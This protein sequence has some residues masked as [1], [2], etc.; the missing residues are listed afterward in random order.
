MNTQFGLKL[1]STNTQLL[2]QAEEAIQNGSFQYVELAVIPNTDI[3]PFLEYD[4]PY[5][6]HATTDTHGVNIA[7]PETYA[8]TTRQIN[9]C[10]DWADK[11]NASTIILHPGIGSTT[12]AFRFLKGLHDDRILIENMPKIG[13]RGEQMAGWSPK[14]I[15]VL[16]G[17]RFGFC[18]DLNHAIKASVSSG[19]P[20]TKM[21]RDF[22]R[23]DPKMFHIADGFLRDG[24]DQ[25]L[26]IGAGDYNIQEL[27]SYIKHSSSHIV[28]LE[29]GRKN[30]D[31]ISEDLDNLNKIKRMG[32]V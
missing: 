27:L 12:A 30:L 11:L 8:F 13:L 17:N 14:Q 22:L 21:I 18:L 4:L 20:Y 31:S 28:T 26:S 6:I 10:I 1:W 29:T 16:I 23:L 25:H 15:E 19:I 7:D 5:Y 32:I 24:I 2:V 9:T 3:S